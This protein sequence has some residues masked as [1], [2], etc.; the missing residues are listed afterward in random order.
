MAAFEYITFTSGL[1]LFLLA[2]LAWFVVLV[3]SVALVAFVYWLR[4]L[5]RRYRARD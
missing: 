5:W 2:C 4:D 3:G 1:A